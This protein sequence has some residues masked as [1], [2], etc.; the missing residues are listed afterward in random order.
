MPQVKQLDWSKL[1]PQQKT[2]RPAYNFKRYKKSAK[3]GGKAKAK[4]KNKPKVID[5]GIWQY[6]EQKITAELMNIG[7]L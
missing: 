7:K 1:Q 5:K 3:K 2:K 6:R 4:L